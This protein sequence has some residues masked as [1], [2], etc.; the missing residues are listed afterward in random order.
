MSEISHKVCQDRNPAQHRAFDV[1]GRIAAL[2]GSE[3]APRPG[4]RAKRA[5]ASADQLIRR[6]NS[7][8]AAI[9]MCVL[10]IRLAPL[11]FPLLSRVALNPIINHRSMVVF[12][13]VW[14]PEQ[15]LL[16]VIA[17]SGMAALISAVGTYALVFLSG[18]CGHRIV[19]DLRSAFYSHILRMPVSYAEKRETG[20][21]LL[22]FIGDSDALRIWY[23]RRQPE[24][25]VDWLLVCI[26]SALL[27]WTDVDLGFLVLAPL[28]LIWLG[29]TLLS[30]KLRRLTRESRAM[31][32]QFSGHIQTRIDAIRQSKWLDACNGF[33]RET[34]TMARNIAEKN[35]RRDGVA[36]VLDAVGFAAIVLMLPLLVWFGVRR[37]WE[38]TLGTGELV[39]ILWLAI[40]LASIIQRLCA[41]IVVREKARVSLARIVSLLGRNAEHGRSSK[42]AQFIPQGSS[43][44]CCGLVP[45]S[46]DQERTPAPY[47][48]RFD[49]PGVHNLKPG[50]T[51]AV[52]LQCILGFHPWER[53]FVTLDDQRVDCVQLAGLRAAVGWVPADPVI[54]PQS[55]EE[56]ILAASCKIKREKL[57][58]LIA[59]S[60]LINSGAEEWL[61]RGAGAGGRKLTREERVL[62]GLFRAIVRK[63]KFIFVEGL[64]SEDMR[65]AVMIAIRRTCKR[66]VIVLDSTAAA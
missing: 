9:T 25:Y 12:G 14:Q 59:N 42:L 56:N 61:A 53:G 8:V 40:H 4:G 62:V 31:Q 41:A 64:D 38:H 11:V 65:Q 3:K 60:G 33:R 46:R 13:A 17:V 49:G 6:Q 36:G 48:L 54:F 16:V 18:K 55:I 44:E 20:S 58:E 51:S 1:L 47:S 5:K 23:A 45:A 7:L 10:L 2:W 22:R 39:A 57:L 32:A 34:A 43:L 19:A 30:P 15:L 28:P 26:I 35:A 29:V 63:P 50:I 37:V 66:A 52:L 24:V 21:V 27:L